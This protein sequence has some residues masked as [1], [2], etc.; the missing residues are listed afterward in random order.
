MEEYKIGRRLLK[1]VLLNDSFRVI[2]FIAMYSLA[3]FLASLQQLEGGYSLDDGIRVIRAVSFALLIIPVMSLLRGFF[4]GYNSMGPSAVSQVVE[5]IIRI[6]FLLGSTFVVMYIVKGSVVT[7]ISLAN[8]FR[9]CRSACKL[10]YSDV[11]FY[12]T[13]KR[14]RSNAP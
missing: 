7:A 5:Q 13:K 12:Q 14:T 9:I 2:C 10:G 11:V 1:R 6:A 3:P 8:I 4:Q